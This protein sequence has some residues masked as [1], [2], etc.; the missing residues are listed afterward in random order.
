MASYEETQKALRDAIVA[1]TPKVSKVTVSGVA[2]DLA[3]T[4]E[5]LANAS[6]ALSE[7]YNVAPPEGD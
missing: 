4:A 1:I 5:R 7:A 6:R 3:E 2:R